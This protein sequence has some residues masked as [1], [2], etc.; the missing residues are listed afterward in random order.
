MT[1]TADESQTQKREREYKLT[2]SNYLNDRI[3]QLQEQLRQ[4]GLSTKRRESL[5]KS[6]TSMKDN[7]RKIKDQS[8]TIKDMNMS[9]KKSTA[10]KARAIEQATS[11]LDDLKVTAAPTYTKSG[12]G[13][14]SRTNTG[15]KKSG[16]SGRKGPGGAKGASTRTSGGKRPPSNTVKKTRTTK[17]V[18]RQFA[19]NEKEFYDTLNKALGG[20][21]D[22][23]ILLAK[24]DFSMRDVLEDMD[25][26]ASRE[27]II[28]SVKKLY[29]SADQFDSEISD[30]NAVPVGKKEMSIIN[31]ATG[32]LSG[33]KP[34][35]AKDTQKQVDGDIAKRA[36]AKAPS[37]N[38]KSTGDSKPRP[39]AKPDPLKDA[40]GKRYTKRSVTQMLKALNE[41]QER[42]RKTSAAYKK[43]NE[44]IKRLKKILKKLTTTSSVSAADTFYLDKVTA[45]SSEDDIKS[46]ASTL[47]LLLG[48][49]YRDGKQTGEFFTFTPESGESR[50]V[51]LSELEDALNDA[52]EYGIKDAKIVDKKA[53]RISVTLELSLNNHEY[54]VTLQSGKGTLQISG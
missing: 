4:D 7:L 8:S 47:G 31:K 20:D 42:G 29:R 54:R 33:T 17:D 35:A 3:N 27:D 10:V 9:T 53:P 5:Q 39:K 13:K 28:Q 36:A 14:M 6:L 43:R 2:R 34:K 25:K 1:D 18:Q 41:Q 40:N 52:D 19:Q 50:R 51:D 15:I 48:I 22:A 12:G 11:A 37:K 30:S 38:T 24:N 45:S 21:K 44:D 23:M 49:A 32:K 26:G 46:I 16:A